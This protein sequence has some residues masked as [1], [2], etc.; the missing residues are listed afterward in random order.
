MSTVIE[1]WRETVGAQGK[2]KTNLLG[3]DCERSM[4]LPVLAS[5]L[6]EKEICQVNM[7]R[8]V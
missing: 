6:E 7:D 5:I 3:K 8:V 2:K 4:E 1:M